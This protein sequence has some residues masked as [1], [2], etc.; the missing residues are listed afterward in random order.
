ME[1]GWNPRNIIGKAA[2]YARSYLVG[3]VP[4]S[5]LGVVVEVLAI[6]TVELEKIVKALPAIVHVLIG[7]E[8]VTRLRHAAVV[9]LYTHTQR[10]PLNIPHLMSVL[11]FYLAQMNPK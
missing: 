7:P 11:W 6:V 4:A 5:R 1:G 3:V 10:A 8:L 2:S 9:H